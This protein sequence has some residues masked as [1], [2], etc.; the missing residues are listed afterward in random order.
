MTR[1]YKRSDYSLAFRLWKPLA[2]QGYAPAQVGIGEGFGVQQ[3]YKQAV[4]WYRKAADQGDASGQYNLGGI[5]NN[6]LGVPQDYTAAARWLRKAADQENDDARGLALQQ[7]PRTDQFQPNPDLVDLTAISQ[8]AERE[9][10]RLERERSIEQQHIQ[11][12]DPH[13]QILSPRGTRRS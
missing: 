13:D 2:D 1:R 4:E 12:L 6:G 11:A 5:Y 8:E 9:H 10:Q 3:N 7:A